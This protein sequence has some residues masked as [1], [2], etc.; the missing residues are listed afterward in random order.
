MIEALMGIYLTLF[1][2]NIICKNKSCFYVAKHC[3][4]PDLWNG[5]E[6]SFYCTLYSNPKNL[7]FIENEYQ[8]GDYIPIKTFTVTEAWRID[9]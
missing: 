3:V 7:K 2:D 9:D 5:I 8:D 6:N 4:Y 1:S